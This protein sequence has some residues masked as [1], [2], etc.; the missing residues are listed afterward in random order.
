MRQGCACAQHLPAVWKALAVQQLQRHCTRQLSGGMSG[1]SSAALLAPPVEL[2]SALAQLPG[3]A[4]LNSRSSALLLS[5]LTNSSCLACVQPITREELVAIL[6]PATMHAVGHVAT[7]VSFAA[8][9]ISFT[10]TIKTLEPG[11]NAILSQLVLGKQPC[12]WATAM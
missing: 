4:M 1:W 9:A 12:S 10:H 2:C 3:A 7:N 11:F 8:V 6:P 5:L